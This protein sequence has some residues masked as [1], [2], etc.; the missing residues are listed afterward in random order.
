MPKRKM[1]ESSIEKKGSK[2]RDQARYGMI[3]D[4]REDFYD[5]QRKL[6]DSRERARAAPKRQV[7]TPESPVLILNVRGIPKDDKKKLLNK[8][9]VYREKPVFDNGKLQKL[10]PSNVAPTDE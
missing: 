4:S 5:G 10:P 7:W 3:R 6:D 1:S 2:D 8:F 9:P